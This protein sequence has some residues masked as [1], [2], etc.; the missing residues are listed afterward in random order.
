[1]PPA[2][3]G[4]EEIV[5]MADMT[6]QPNRQPRQL[7]HTRIGRMITSVTCAALLAGT[8]PAPLF[9]QQPPPPPPNGQQQQGYSPEQ[10]DAV[11]AP[12]AL[13]PDQLL[14]QVL[15]A[16]AFPD[17]VQAAAQWVAQPANA[18]LQ[19]DQLANALVPLPWDPSVKSLVPFPQVLQQM[20]AQQ[21]WLQQLG[22]AVSVQQPDVM[23]SVQR[24]RKQAEIA[25]QLHSSDHQVVSNDGGSIV[26]APAQPNVVYVPSYNPVDVYG[27][28]PYPDYPPFYLPPPVGYVGYGGAAVVGG[29]AFGAG[30]AIGAFATAGLWGWARP[31]WGGGN[32]FI[33]VNNYNRWSPGRPWNGGPNWHPYR[34][35]GRPGWGYRRPAAAFHPP[36]GYR[37]GPGYRPG[38]PGYRPGVRPPP[39]VVPRGG[40]HPGQPPAGVRPGT[41]PGERPGERPGTRPGNERPGARPGGE[42]PGARP[43]GERPGARPGGERPGARPGGE[44]PGGE[45]PGARPGGERPGGER[46][47]PRPESRPAPHAAAPRPAPHPAAPRPAPHPSGGGGGG[48]REHK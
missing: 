15:M 22:Y 19:G 47:A 11:L 44:R 32:V 37:P 45:R 34:P 8:A 24:L 1:M 3:A 46:P 25:G 4:P 2:G 41:R 39:P 27:A 30:I 10:L 12:I 18:Q 14:T 43:G 9:A 13:Y 21:D 40:V 6:G 17:Q 31:N 29:L 48:H 23:A 35:V 5:I 20:T 38:A 7:M 33:N 36:G 26:I 28:W 42:R 16:S